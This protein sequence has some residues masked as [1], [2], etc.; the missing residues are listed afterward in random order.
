VVVHRT[1]AVPPI[2]A[3]VFDLFDTLVDLHMDRIKPLEFRG[4]WLSGT[5]PALH[6]AFSQEIAGVDFE[7]FAEA[8]HA[9]DSEFRRTRYA[10]CLELPTEE[11]FEALLDHL[12]RSAPGL[13]DKLV[14]VHM[15]ALREHVTHVD[16]H[17]G[18]LDALHS[19]ARLALCSNFSHSGTAIRIL[20]EASLRAHLDE[21]VISDVRGFR[22][23]RSE[24]FHEVLDALGVSPEET[25]HVG[26]NIVADVSGAAAIG[27]RTVWL[28][29]RVRDP[30]ARLAK[31]E[32]PSPDYEMADLAE[33]VPLVGADN[34]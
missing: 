16:H 18:V 15:G 19:K 21:I 8:L 26:D 23:P 6:D 13:V 9:V 31:Y 34:A 20:E 28:T 27:I 22:K 1:R 10:E 25:L 17:P 33:L 29:R 2:R 5:A 14:D 7:H 3:I 30:E 11:R 24:I 12:G 4:T 32:G